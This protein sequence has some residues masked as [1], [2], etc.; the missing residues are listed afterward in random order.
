MAGSMSRVHSLR[1]AWVQLRL[2]VSDLQHRATMAID[3]DAASHEWDAMAERLEQAA[4]LCRNAARDRLVR[5]LANSRSK[6]LTCSA[7]GDVRDE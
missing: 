6:Y 1:P 3:S 5:E 2:A 4:Q 7:T